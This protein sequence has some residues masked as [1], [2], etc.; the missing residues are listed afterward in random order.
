MHYIISTYI[1]AGLRQISEPLLAN[2]SFV[3]ALATLLPSALQQA[4][5]QQLDVS[6]LRY[7]FQFRF[8]G[9]VPCPTLHS[10]LQVFAKS[11]NIDAGPE[12]TNVI[13]HVR[14][15][16]RQKTDDKFEHTAGSVHVD[17]RVAQAAQP[18]YAVAAAGCLSTSKSADTMP[19]TSAAPAPITP[20]LDTS[21]GTNII[22]LPGG[23]TFSNAAD[24]KSEP[25]PTHPSHD[26]QKDTHSS[27]ANVQLTN[28][29]AATQFRGNV[30][31]V[32]D[33]ESFQ[34]QKERRQK[35][36]A[37]LLDG[38]ATGPV[39]GVAHG[40]SWGYAAQQHAVRMQNGQVVHLP[41][42]PNR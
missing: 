18:Q 15:V 20:V 37:F 16:K 25:Q 9:R 4:F 38:T 36:A 19:L 27:T 6:G 22:P 21:T 41:V 34:R 23:K 35:K 2:H 24:H 29:A 39:V 10:S 42:R 14:H 17:T 30:K 31:R 26:V 28:A 40:S 7:S 1:P 13:Q 33:A 11:K 5:L 32:R 12:Q 8:V 3:R